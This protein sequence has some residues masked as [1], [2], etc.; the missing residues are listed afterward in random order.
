MSK[1]DKFMY[2]PVLWSNV[3]E[4]PSGLETFAMCSGCRGSTALSGALCVEPGSDICSGI[5]VRNRVSVVS[6]PD[7]L[8]NSLTVIGGGIAPLRVRKGPTDG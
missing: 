5:Q 1:F 3:D 2:Y 8:A 6:V 4:G 7:S